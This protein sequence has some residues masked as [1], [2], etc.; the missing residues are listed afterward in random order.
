M[1][2]AYKARRPLRGG[3]VER[4]LVPRGM[5]AGAES[6]CIQTASDEATPRGESAARC[7]GCC[8]V[9]W[10][11]GCPT[12]SAELGLRAGCVPGRGEGTLSM[13]G[14][15]PGTPAALLPGGEGHPAE[16]Q[17]LLPCR[18]GCTSKIQQN[19]FRAVPMSSVLCYPEPRA[20][21]CTQVKHVA[22]TVPLWL[23]STHKV[24]SGAHLAH[25]AAENPHWPGSIG[26]SNACFLSSSQRT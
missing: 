13:A 24:H 5:A 22:G 15:V 18:L 20:P 14:A 10:A 3:G 6:V 21:L 12:C 26:R 19:V 1:N 23:P 11:L 9:P 4:N 7:G 16:A 8:C 2:R 17:C 25:K